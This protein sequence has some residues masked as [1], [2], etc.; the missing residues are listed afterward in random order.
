MAQE[1]II[2][3]DGSE[4]SLDALALGRLLAPLVDRELLMA[5]VYHYGPGVLGARTPRA[6]PR[7]YRR[8]RDLARK[9]ARSARGA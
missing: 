1:V 8:G 6:R 4:Q 3:F 7:N 2:G 9:C 5:G